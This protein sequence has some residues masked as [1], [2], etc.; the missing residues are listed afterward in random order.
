M[1]QAKNQDTPMNQSKLEETT[2]SWRKE[3]ESHEW[4]GLDDKAARVYFEQ[5]LLGA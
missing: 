5:I 3:M 2:C 4:F 1:S